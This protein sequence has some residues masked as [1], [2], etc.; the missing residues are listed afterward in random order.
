MSIYFS[1]AIPPQMFLDKCLPY[2]DGGEPIKE[3]I[4]YSLAMLANAPMKTSMSQV[5]VLICSKN[6]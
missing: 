1:G 4:G 6:P 3:A 5:N 2:K